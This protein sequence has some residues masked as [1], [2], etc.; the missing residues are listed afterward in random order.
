MRPTIEYCVSQLPEINTG[1]RIIA[2]L[3]YK[4]KKGRQYLDTEFLST[5]DIMQQSKT[6]VIEEFKQCFDR[7][8][9]LPDPNRH[10][11]SLEMRVGVASSAPGLDATVEPSINEEGELVEV[12]LPPLDNT[13][14]ESGDGCMKFINGSIA[15]VT[16]SF[17]LASRASS[18]VVEN[19]EVRAQDPST[20]DG[21]EG[22]QLYSRCLTG[23][24][25]TEKFIFG[26][27]IDNNSIVASSTAP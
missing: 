11:S 25:G 8:L 27:K 18:T 10:C 22:F 23:A 12:A 7:A 15:K 16:L 1:N 4:N 24:L 6:K 14:R 17:N 3:Q 13:F 19:W 26:I 9:D 21:R 20:T 2:Q 5:F